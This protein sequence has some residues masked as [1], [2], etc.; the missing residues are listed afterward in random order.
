[1][2]VDKSGGHF[3]QR[4]LSGERVLAGSVPGKAVSG[5]PALSES[6]G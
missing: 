3:R 2:G 1:M 4:A 6:E 5:H